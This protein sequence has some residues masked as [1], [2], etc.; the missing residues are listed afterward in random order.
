MQGIDMKKR[1]IVFAVMLAVL[2]LAFTACAK[3]PSGLLEDEIKA[4]YE[5]LIPRSQEMNV[6]LW[7]E[8]IA[9]EDNASALDSVTAAQYYP[10]SDSS[11]YQSV[12]DLMDAL[13]GIFSDGYMN[14]ITAS[15]FT[16]TIDPDDESYNIYPRYIDKKGELCVDITYEGFKLATEID[17]SSMT[18]VKDTADTIICEFDYVYDMEKS[19]TKKITIVNEADGWRLDSPTY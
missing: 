11:P 1:I 6:I 5:D 7:G 14:I 15:V 19:G 12:N 4:I 10:V 13:S 2:A 17:M 16:E 3:K 18:V 9:P 8:G